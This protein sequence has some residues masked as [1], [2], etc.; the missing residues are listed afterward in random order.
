MT[1]KRIVW[2]L[3]IRFENG[4]KLIICLYERGFFCLKLVR[5]TSTTRKSCRHYSIPGARYLVWGHR[6]HR[7]Q[8]KLLSPSIDISTLHADPKQ[9]YVQKIQKDILL[10]G[11][12]HICQKS[13]FISLWPYRILWTMIAG[14]HQNW[15][16]GACWPNKKEIR[17]NP[18]PRRFCLQIRTFCILSLLEDRASGNILRFRDHWSSSDSVPY[19]FILVPDA[20]L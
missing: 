2:S 16:L 9:T 4:V 8:D 7:I 11:L 15:N 6:C 1:I 3:N 20:W 12:Y 5:L 19:S 10:A 18:G 14:P 13:S 17:L